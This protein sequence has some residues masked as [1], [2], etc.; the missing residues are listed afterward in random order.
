M[1][2]VAIAA[3]LMLV[4]AVPM[5]AATDG[6]RAAV[7]S[8]HRHTA[9]NTASTGK[10]V[11]KFSAGCLIGCQFHYAL[12]QSNCRW[13]SGV[14]QPGYCYLDDICSYCSWQC[15]EVYNACITC[16]GGGGW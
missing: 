2:K 16:Q 1:K 14:A 15:G 13:V 3:V 9:T 12:C 5:T 10:V 4:A 8:P 6:P 11:E 7:K